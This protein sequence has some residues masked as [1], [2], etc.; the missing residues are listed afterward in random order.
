MSRFAL[1]SP[2]QIQPIK[3][4]T[5]L[6]QPV[7]PHFPA[8]SIGLCALTSYYW[9][10]VLYEFLVIDHCNGLKATLN[11]FL[12]LQSRPKSQ[13]ASS[14]SSDRSRHPL[15]KLK[16]RKIRN[17]PENPGSGFSISWCW[18][19]VLQFLGTRCY[20][21]SYCQLSNSTYKKS[22]HFFSKSWTSLTWRSGPPDV[23]HSSE[24]Q[25]DEK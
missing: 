23:R 25:T 11:I 9:S 22:V 24:F 10:I 17:R 2:S 12:S 6:S 21:W 3:Y 4:K 15:D 8:L 7:C 20:T 16:N 19:K 18:L 14:V 13:C 5:N 1:L